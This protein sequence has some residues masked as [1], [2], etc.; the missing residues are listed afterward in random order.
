[1]RPRSQKTKVV[2]VRVS[3]PVPTEVVI[4]RSLLT[5]LFLYFRSTLT[6]L[7]IKAAVGHMPQRTIPMSCCNDF[8]P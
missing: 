4:I 1:M 5:E 6:E 7:S 8:P 3:L 2:K